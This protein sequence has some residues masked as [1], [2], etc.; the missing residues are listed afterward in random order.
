VV[1]DSI[2]G[3]LSSDGSILAM[4]EPDEF[5]MVADVLSV[6]DESHSRMRPNQLIVVGGVIEETDEFATLLL[7]MGVELFVDGQQVDQVVQLL[8]RAEHVH[9][10]HP[11]QFAIVVFQ[12]LTAEF[13]LHSLYDK[14][15][16]CESLSHFL[17][18]RSFAVVNYVLIE[19]TVDEYLLRERKLPGLIHYDPPVHLVDF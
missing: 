4:G 18:I 17:N 9:S 16:V 6:I 14:L 19:L 11:W 7:E 2:D 15:A 5:V 13:P 10:H 3:E 12:S 8:L 1:E